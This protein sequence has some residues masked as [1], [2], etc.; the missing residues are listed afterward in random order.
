MEKRKLPKSKPYFK[1][2]DPRAIPYQ[3]EVINDIYEN[4]D[5]S[6]GVHEIMLS[7]S[8]G[9]AKSELMAHIAIRHCLEFSGA[10]FLLGR[11]AMPQLKQTIL[12]KVL[13]HMHGLKEGYH[14]KANKTNGSIQFKNG[15]EIMCISWADK[16]YEKMRSYEFSAAAIEELTENDSDEFEAM[17][18]ELVGRVGRVN[19]MNSDVTKNFIIYATNPDSP[20]HSAYNY[21]IKGCETYATRHVYYSLTRDNPFL[22]DW[23]EKGLRDKYDSKQI[24]RFLEGKWI[25]I[26]T[27]S[28]YYEYSSQVHYVL[29]N[30]EVSPKYPLRI[31]FD[32]NIGNNK[33]MSAVAF[34]YDHAHNE[35][36]F[37]DEFVIEGA[38]TLDIMEEIAGRGYFDIAFNP[39]II[40]HGD[41]SGRH[42]DTRNIK[43]DYYLIE[44]FLANYKRKRGTSRRL[45]FDIDVPLA[46]PAIR[47][48]H[49]TVNGHLRNANGRVSIKIDKRCKTLDEGFTKVKLIE[50]GKYIEDDSK[51]YQHITTAA[52]YGLVTASKY[53]DE[54]PPITGGS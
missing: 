42:N 21:F 19:S 6:L 44:E 34:Q 15:A 45:E 14:Y 53:G 37:I 20:V 25:H 3:Y 2:F 32:F 48:R 52:G 9:S 47:D 4:F 13:N 31:S 26:G 27:D 7:G 54:L 16:N 41:S 33:P 8:V 12:K 50:T 46:N 5:Y 43:S 40:I 22:P 51:P 30:T 49:N 17:H 39:V 1:E 11:R 36:I 28:V 10:R 38:R 29:E 35:G 23:Y 24:Q 18:S